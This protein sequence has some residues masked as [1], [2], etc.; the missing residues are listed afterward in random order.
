M[1]S[2]RYYSQR[3]KE[4]CSGLRVCIRDIGNFSL[5]KALVA[6]LEFFQKEGVA[7]KFSDQFSH[8]PGMY[9]VKELVQG[10]I[11]RK[12]FEAE[13]KYELEQFFVMASSSFIYKPY[14]KV[15]LV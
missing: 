10:T 8:I 5:F 4:F 3:K 11:K 6:T 1:A 15:V 7:L 2:Y 9:K 12:D 14:P 13:L